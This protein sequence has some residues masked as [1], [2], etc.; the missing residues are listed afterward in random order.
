M[1]LKVLF[2]LIGCIWGQHAL[3]H[4]LNF[5]LFDL[6]EKE[7]LFYM[8]IR[9]DKVN[10]LKAIGIDDYSQNIQSLQ[11]EL[12]EYLNENIE[13]Q[14]NNM[15]TWLKYTEISSTEDV[16]VILAKVIAPH[17][18]VS[19]IQIRNTILL[20][21]VDTQTNIIKTYFHERNRSFRLNA[22]RTSTLIKY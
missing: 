18:P 4:E 1:N 8:E 7:N 3:G 10:T 12:T 15:K 22:D 11:C 21:E 17:Q 9:L 5:G 19:E 14:I 20:S 2:V 13:L 16:V 6:Y